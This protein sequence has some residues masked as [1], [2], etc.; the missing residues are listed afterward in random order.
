MHVLSAPLLANTTEEK[1]SKGTEYLRGEC[2][3]LCVGFVNGMV[4]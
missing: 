4:R 3:Y 1:P 2:V